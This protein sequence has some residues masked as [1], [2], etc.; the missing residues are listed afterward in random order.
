MNQLALKSAAIGFLLFVALWIIG[1][2]R[3]VNAGEAEMPDLPAP[4]PLSI[5][6]SDDYKVG[7]RLANNLKQIGMQQT[8]LPQVLAQADLDQV[9]IY[10]KSAHLAAGSTAFTDDE[11]SI[12]EAITTHKASVFSERA[13]G[14]APRRSLALGIAVAPAQ[15]DS[16]LAALSKVG[17]LASINVQQQDRTS[18]FR[19]LHAQRQSL[20]KH[21]EA[22]LKLRGAGKLSAEEALKVEQKIM[23]LDKEIQSVAIQLGGLLNR[24][25]AYNLFIT[26]QEHRPGSWQDKAGFNLTRGLGLGFAWAVGW[27]FTIAA[28]LG[29]IGLSYASVRTIAR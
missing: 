1:I 9:E 10:E 26:L 28:G 16:L 5:A 20:A 8:P 14:L 21:Q 22:I 2:V 29:V 23:E 6:S 25:P 17:Q 13:S 7:N 24:E 15:F 3:N 19:K 27:W 18:E 11:A 12:R 4:I